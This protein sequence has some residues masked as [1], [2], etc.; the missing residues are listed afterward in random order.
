MCC[1]VWLLQYLNG[2]RFRSV[3]SVFS[4][5]LSS[6]LN[7]LQQTSPYFVRCINPNGSKKPDSFEIDYVLKQLR[8]GNASSWLVGVGVRGSR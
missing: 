8:Y 5:Q 1:A 4:T 2:N 3:S 6:L 7:Q